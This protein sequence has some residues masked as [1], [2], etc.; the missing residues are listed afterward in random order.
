MFLFILGRQPEIG[1]AE[2]AAV[3][4]RENVREIS[5]SLRGGAVRNLA[6][7]DEISVVRAAERRGFSR[8]LLGESADAKAINLLFSQLGSVVK[9]AR[10][11]AKIADS[12]E[13]K[14]TDF[15]DEISRNFGADGGKI[16]LG[17][18][19]ETREISAG[20]LDVVARKVRENLAKNGAS[21]REIFRDRGEE[22]LNS[23]SVFH[24]KLTGESSR[25]AEVIF[26]KNAGEKFAKNDAGISRKNDEFLLA[27]TVYV[28]D[29]T[30]YTFRDRSRP[31][32]DAKVGMLP[33]KLAQTIINLATEN[34]E[35]RGK[36]L[37]DAFV[38][39]GVILQEFALM[40][41]AVYG[42]DIEPRMVEFTDEK[43]AFVSRKFG[44]E[45]REIGA[46]RDFA[47]KLEVGSATEMKW[48][49]A[50]AEFAKSDE[51]VR[52]NSAPIFPD[53][54]AGETYLGRAYATEPSAENLREN[55]GNVNKILTEF[56]RNLRDQASAETGVCLAVPAWFISRNG[57]EKTL[58]LP[59]LKELES[60]GF[61]RKIGTENLVYRREGQ[62]VGRE[63]VVLTKISR[64]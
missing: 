45:F 10:V 49:F 41:G 44:R 14:L 40:G 46:D 24:N 39:T 20:N 48:N 27:K 51:K 13:L 19:S 18:S 6:M 32:R 2:L 60:L 11:F 29:I 17:F 54:V 56:L 23:A 12:R 9:V 52:D 37:L 33:P 4:G 62:I 15:A 61:Q 34:R 59:L 42:T 30:S 31:K 57:R 28:Q 36:I 7:V 53:F 1:F 64:K 16:T 63:L 43:L 50:G 35:I 5:D 26:V 38:G 22:K 21:F 3:F 8:N 55:I 47:R 58:Y 25:K